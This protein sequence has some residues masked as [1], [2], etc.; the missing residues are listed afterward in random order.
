VHFSQIASKK[1]H[2]TNAA[3]HLIALEPL[4][5][6]LPFGIQIAKVRGALESSFSHAD[7]QHLQVVEEIIVLGVEVVI[8]P[9]KAWEMLLQARLENLPHLWICFNFGCK[10]FFQPWQQALQAP[11]CL[12]ININ[13]SVDH[14]CASSKA[15]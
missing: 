10:F 7:E 14:A 12:L 8:E 9:K 4:R 3:D 15:C 6:G 5:I 1:V 11:G 13:F 2:I